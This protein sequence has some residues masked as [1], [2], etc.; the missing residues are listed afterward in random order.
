MFHDPLL[1]CNNSATKLNIKKWNNYKLFI[2]ILL[3]Y[4]LIDIDLVSLQLYTHIF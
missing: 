1:L 2:K 3:F 4:T